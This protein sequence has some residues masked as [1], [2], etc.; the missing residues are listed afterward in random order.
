MRKNTF[1][2][3]V[4]A[5]CLWFNLLNAQ[6]NQTVSPVKIGSILPESFWK[7]EH[8]IYAGGKISKQ[9]LAQYKDKLLILDF[10]ATWCTS[11]TKKFKYLDSIQ[12]E[13]E[14]LAVILL[15]DA[16][17]TRDTPEKIAK[18]MKR[19]DDKLSSIVADTVLTKQ[20]IH[21]SV[22]HYIWIAGGNFLAAT[23]SE[24][25]HKGNLD[26]IL[27]RQ[28]MLKEGK[29]KSVESAIKK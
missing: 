6:T 28:Q 1:L 29:A 26:A 21:T 16:K 23:G 14:G 4:A 12:K 18:M 7:Q 22:P 3:A 27:E 19:F 9:S 13:Y 25:M 8:S 20:F 5:L 2:Y 17:D 15:V 24:F 10:W 11:C